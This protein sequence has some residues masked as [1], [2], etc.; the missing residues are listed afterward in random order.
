MESHASRRCWR[1]ATCLQ[2]AVWKFIFWKIDSTG[3]PGPYQD[4]N[5]IDRTH[6][7]AGEFAKDPAFAGSRDTGLA[8][9]HDWELLPNAFANGL[10]NLFVSRTLPSVV[11]LDKIIIGGCP[12]GQPLT[13]LF[14]SYQV[15]AFCLPVEFF[16]YWND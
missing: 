15:F 9:D 7:S 1:A 13:A 5:A 16:A 6:V 11:R 2:R 3:V 8:S 10:F 12:F 4:E 14:F